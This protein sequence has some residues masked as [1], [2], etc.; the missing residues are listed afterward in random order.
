VNLQDEISVNEPYRR[1]FYPNVTQIEKA[2]VITVSD[3]DTVT[4]INLVIPKVEE[5]I[6]VSGIL[7]FSDGKPVSDDDVAAINFKALPREGFKTDE[8]EITDD[9]RFT[10]KIVKGLKG[11]L[12]GVFAAQIGEYADCPKLDALLMT[13]GYGAASLKSTTIPIEGDRNVDNV[14]LRFPFP[15]CK[16]KEVEPR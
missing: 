16:R 4:G 12:F 15:K 13:A 2:A 5:T 14:V 9:G 1:L 8:V 7:R 3:G 6:T 10:F 11:E